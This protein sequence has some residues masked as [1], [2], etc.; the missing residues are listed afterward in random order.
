MGASD[1]QD[2]GANR[3]VDSGGF[4]APMSE[5]PSGPGLPFARRRPAVAALGAAAGGILLGQSSL[6]SHWWWAVAGALVSAFAL[7]FVLSANN[8]LRRLIA[9]LV[10]AALCCIFALRAGYQQF[11][12][13]DSHVRNLVDSG[14]TATV[15]G[16][17]SDW[18]DI[19]DHKTLLTLSVDSVTIAGK[20]AAYNGSVLLRIAAPTNEFQYSDRLI[21]T[22]ELRA[23]A[24]RKNPGGF[25]YARYL[26]WKDIFA[27]IYLPHPYGIQR[28]APAVFSISALVESIRT[29]IVDVFS[30]TLEPEQSALASGFLIGE[31][32]RIS[33]T[34]YS[35]FRNSGTLHLLAVSG[36]NVAIV[37]LTLRLFLWPFP[38]S[39]RALYLILIAGAVLFCLVSQNEPSVVRATVMVSVYLLG[40]ILER[41]L[42]FHNGIAA[43]GLLILLWN[44]NQMF[45][46]G[47]QLS[48][49]VAWMIILAVENC[50]RLFKR[51]RRRRWYRFVLL[52]LVVALAA[53]LSAAPISLYYFHT[54]PAWSTPANL[55]IG[56]LVTLAV[57]LSLV[58]L[59]VSLLIPL[60]GVFIGSG[61]NYLLALILVALEFFG[62]A[63]APIFRSASLGA[64]ESVALLALVAVAGGALV[65]RRARRALVFSLAILP[66]VFVGSRSELLASAGDSLW[67]Y[68]TRGGVAA[69]YTGT[70]PVLVLADCNQAPEALYNYT[71]AGQLR[72]LTDLERLT[73]LALSPDF[74]TLGAALMVADSLPVRRL[75]LTERLRPLASDLMAQQSGAQAQAL[76]F[77][78]LGSLRDTAFGSELRALES[79]PALVAGE[80]VAA[81]CAERFAALFVAQVFSPDELTLALGALK[82]QSEIEVLY[83][84]CARPT[85]RLVRFLNNFSGAGEIQLIFQ[86][87]ESQS[88]QAGL[89]R[90]GKVNGVRQPL[91]LSE[92][93]AIE[94]T[95]R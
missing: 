88:E 21:V 74:H 62:G 37:L 23:P 85:A 39:R 27:V 93:G 52:P 79:R 33:D 53:Q 7:L 34:V 17:V 54:A 86:S 28:D 32:S 40:R 35:H 50:N 44:P 70:E 51:F 83:L 69:L 16:L 38:L 89:F 64:W 9:P 41:R 72:S 58:I 25:D 95:E 43:A 63:Q 66:L 8:A 1:E 13:A 60:L 68:S 94:I 56:P 84:I 57:G 77:S 73:A 91:F 46:V 30:A 11:G 19:H 87:A 24:G 82:S 71:L 59:S 10:V 45:D 12:A 90:Q 3:T 75:Y 4:S 61:L 78:Y 49:V 31:T 76:V 5:G 18:P 15:Y 26:R 42:E 92:T 48:F 22:G 20:T 80:T 2:Q 67:L 6:V 14:H 29:Y 47:F 36:S 81:L 65:S 55:L